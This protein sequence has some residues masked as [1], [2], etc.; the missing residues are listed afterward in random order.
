MWR[1]RAHRAWIGIPILLV[2]AAG[3]LAL[4]LT[5]VPEA[6]SP[7]SAPGRRTPAP[8]D[9]APAVPS[10]GPPLPA[11]P[12]PSNPPAAGPSVAALPADLPPG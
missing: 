9:G 11:A 2:L 12:A 8:T 6:A 4:A 10:T 7:P 1:W 5:V 3:T